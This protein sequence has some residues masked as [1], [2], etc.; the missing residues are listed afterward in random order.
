M[1]MLEC[2]AEEK[3]KITDKEEVQKTMIMQA[4]SKR[5]NLFGTRVSD[6]IKLC[7]KY[8]A[9]QNDDDDDDD[10]DGEEEDTEMTDTEHSQTVTDQ[11]RAKPNKRQ[12]QRRKERQ[13]KDKEDKE[14]KG[15]GRHE[16]HIGV[17]RGTAGSCNNGC[18][19][20]LGEHVVATKDEEKAAND[21]V[22]R[23]CFH[24]GEEEPGKK[25]GLNL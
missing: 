25:I 19:N 3:V 20:C 24:E 4:T 12:R 13:A 17:P 10:D 14:G 2:G 16:H 9:L 22:I 1:M 15:K 6:P 21:H 11:R 23:N 18:N 7:N 5:D 8:K